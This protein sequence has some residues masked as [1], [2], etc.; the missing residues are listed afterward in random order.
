[1]LKTLRPLEAQGEDGPLVTLQQTAV[2][3]LRGAIVRG[4]L[5][6]G[7]WLKVG[8]VAQAMG[9]STTPTREALVQLAGEGLVESVPHRGHRVAPLDAAVMVEVLQVQIRLW[10]LGYEWGVPR[11]G[12]AT[13]Q[14]LEDHHACYVA[15]I[16]AGDALS[17]VQAA[18]RFH[19]VVLNASGNRELMRLSQ[20]RIALVQRFV[21][22]HA[23]DI[24]AWAMCSVTKELLQAVVR[25]DAAAA[26]THFG[27]MSQKLLDLALVLDA[28]AASGTSAASA[29]P[30]ESSPRKKRG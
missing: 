15:A 18:H 25:R 27:Y 6:P 21:A 5:P 28:R 12:V 11:L 26:V 17:T 16:Q 8:D 20:D 4:D 22:L 9:L 14:Q 10:A 1:M 30:K 3:L 7:A 24:D 29:D 2:A 19:G 23:Q 13:V